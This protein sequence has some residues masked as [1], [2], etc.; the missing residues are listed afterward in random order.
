MH[1]T[2]ETQKNYSP[3]DIVAHCLWE[4][5]FFGFRYSEV[6]KKKNE[7]IESCLEDGDYYT[8]EDGKIIPEDY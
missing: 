2:E 7:L 5:T 1:F 8:I 6:E 4:M 3:A